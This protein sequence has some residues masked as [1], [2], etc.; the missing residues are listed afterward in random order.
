MPHQQAADELGSKLLGGAA[1]EGV[2]EVLERR[3]GYGSG[4]AWKC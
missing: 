2:E 1:K 3:G 4:Y